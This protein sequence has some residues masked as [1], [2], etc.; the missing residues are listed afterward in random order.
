M[1]KVVYGLEPQPILDLCTKK[2]GT[3]GLN[4]KLVD[5]LSSVVDLIITCIWNFITTKVKLSRV[6]I[7]YFKYILTN[8]VFHIYGLNL[9]KAL[10]ISSG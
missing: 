1:F 7:N 2:F 8:S 4:Q 10:K 3:R 6:C 9:V 5:S